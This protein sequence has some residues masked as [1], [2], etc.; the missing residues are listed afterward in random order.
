MITPEMTS[1]WPAS[2][3]L[4]VDGYL[5]M[6]GLE[7]QLLGRTDLA[8]VLLRVA[9]GAAD[10]FVRREALGRFAELTGR[11]ITKCPSAMPPW[12]PKPV[13]GRPRGMVFTRVVQPYPGH[14]NTDMARRYSSL[15]VGMTQ[16]QAMAHGITA[17]DIR[18]WKDKGHVELEMK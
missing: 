13:A 17:R 10:D 3:Q 4:I 1:G 8:L 16:E 2:L 5:S 11:A 6:H 14:K 18:V 9:D 7:P 15:K 12:P